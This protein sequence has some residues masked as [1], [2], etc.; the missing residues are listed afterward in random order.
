MSV[1]NQILIVNRIE[2]GL[3][4]DTNV[5]CSELMLNN[6]NLKQNPPFQ[7][8]D[9]I[10]IR[11]ESGEGC[12]GAGRHAA[13][14]DLPGGHYLSPLRQ[15]HSVPG[16]TQGKEARR[17]Q[18]DRCLPVQVKSELPIFHI[19]SRDNSIRVRCRFAITHI[20]VFSSSLQVLPQHIFKSRDPI[21][22]GVMVENGI[23]KVGTPICV[24]SK[25]VS[26]FCNLLFVA[27]P[28]EQMFRG[29]EKRP[30]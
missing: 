19:L 27:L 29:T 23:V 22:M 10:S 21:V 16:R 15:V 11:R 12:T 5:G 20:R 3:L 8:G 17:V 26:I 6:C 25:S 13:R 2:P 7:M 14:Q 9:N 1:N 18:A 24:P 28:T 4:A 30:D